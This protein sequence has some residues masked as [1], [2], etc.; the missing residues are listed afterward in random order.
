MHSNF[1]FLNT[2][3]PTLAKT[4]ELAE[5]LLYIDANGC[6]IKLR[7]ISELIAKLLLKEE[8]L[9]EVE[10][11]NQ[12][13]RIKLLQRED[14]LPYE[15]GSFFHQLRKYGNMAA[16]EGFNS[17]DQAKSCLNIA[18]RLC[19]WLVQS[20]GNDEDFNAEGFSYIEPVN[21]NY[22]HEI[23]RLKRELDKIQQEF[24]E[25]N[26]QKCSKRSF[27]S[28]Q[29]ASNRFITN[30]ELSEAETREIIDL[31][32]QMVGWEA[33][34]KKLRFATGCR[35]QKGKNLAI[36][37]WPTQKGFVDYALFCGL[38]LLGIVEAKKQSVDILSI[39]EEAKLY[40]R[41][42][43]PENSDYFVNNSQ[44]PEYC[45]PF[46][47]ATNG[48]KYLKQLE[49]KS[50]IWFLDGRKPT[51]IS[52]VL[53]NWFSPL[54]LQNLMKQDIA[55][56]EKHLQTTSTDFLTSMEGLKLRY[57]Q[58]DAVK[59]VEQ[60][61]L[62]RQKKILLAM[63]T[64]TGKTKTAIAMI[65]RFLEAN[66]FKRILFLV[67][68]SS[69]GIQAADNFKESKIKDL[70]TLSQIYDIK[71]VGD[72]K[73]EDT[74]RV[75]IA[76]VQ[77]MVR[78]V[79]Y[80]YDGEIMPS[81]GQYDCIIVDEAHR[82][83]ILETELSE[84]ELRF[85]DQED[86]ISKYRAVIDYFDAYKIGL[87]A[88][89]ALHT[90]D[91]FGKAAF[92]YSYRQAVVDG[93]LVDHE[94]PYIIK[95]TLN[96]GGIKLEKDKQIDVFDPKTNEIVAQVLPDD[97]FFN[98]EG[99]N[100]SVITEPFNQAALKEIAA[101][102]DPLGEAKT[103]IFAVNNQ[104]AD[105]IVKILKDELLKIGWEISDN[106]VQR[107][108]GDKNQEENIKRFK[109]ERNPNIA[110][111][112]DLLTTGI[113]VEEIVNL[114]FLRK[115]KSRILYEQ[116][117]G[118]ATRL[119]PQIGKE[120]FRIYD[121][122]GL[123]DT[124]K[125]YTTMKPVVKNPDLSFKVLIEQFDL[126]NNDTLARQMQEILVKLQRK[127]IVIAKAEKQEAFAILSGGMTIE[128]YILDLK[129]QKPEQ[130]AKQ[131]KANPELFDFLDRVTYTG[132]GIPISDL[133][134]TL[135]E[136]SRGYGKHNVKPEDYLESFK[137]FLLENQDKITAL[138]LLALN[139]QKLSRHDLK[140]LL[141]LMD[142]EGFTENFLNSAVKS[143]KKVD[144]VTDLIILIKNM[145]ENTPIISHEERIKNSMLTIRK[146]KSW[147]K[148]QIDWL[149]RMEKQLLLENILQKE[150][151]DQG[152]FREHG[153]FLKLN[154]IFNDEL[155][156]I[157]TQINEN[158][159]N[160]TA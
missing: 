30:L 82:G 153:G 126:H 10:S 139:P 112:V 43:R 99:F 94:P 62:N 77:G 36:A 26:K 115:V 74:T 39:L 151:F 140:E 42:M 47:F 101:Q 60:R 103:L 59:T 148:L 81:V 35:P 78:R 7:T 15:I 96:Q 89:P 152:A 6:L 156:T 24:A 91:I 13:D 11:N 45:V 90:V 129:T 145:V 128:D 123:Y 134:D 5:K 92:E 17:I 100:R 41:T 95:T 137:T 76:T 131:I 133:P 29:R 49:S 68:R 71:E 23:E 146:M 127:K 52:K 80:P 3:W 124:L 56:A 102:L 75:H 79:M 84:D 9:P 83:Y 8:N 160:I 20:Y 57:Y 120:C 113:D 121:A 147:N 107:I 150:D 28:K 18:F 144:I 65:Y 55:E 63:A 70:Q 73:S 116:M 34:T 67:D 88:T 109:N 31:Q 98:V 85:K 4:A 1:Q 143:V 54:D 64:G 158:L 22:D 149:N 130:A 111:T 114:V 119:C 104:H 132:N 141:I 14:V 21:A 97:L 58:V 118:R 72:S 48:R 66:R 69:L 2:D 155:E 106:T 142:K 32:L 16:H 27:E 12:I 110:V 154:K 125:S 86:Y 105:L 117:L 136:T 108:T 53:Q 61:I 38:Q 25:L 33:D 44:N 122:V 50:G 46:M 37:E 19:C 157:I 87:T 159:Y 135:I 93:F 51:N 138:K 40:S